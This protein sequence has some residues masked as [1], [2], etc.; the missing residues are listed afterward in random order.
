[1]EPQMKNS[2][3]TITTYSDGKPVASAEGLNREEAVAA[4]RKAM[5]G[6]D[7]LT[8]A[9]AYGHAAFAPVEIEPQTPAEGLPVAA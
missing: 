9:T 2:S 1:M 4:I 8:E 6:S 3:W 7:P 5:Y